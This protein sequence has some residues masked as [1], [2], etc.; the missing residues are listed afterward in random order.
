V[1]RLASVLPQDLS[2]QIIEAVI[3]LFNGSEFE[4]VAETDR[5]RISDPGGGSRGDARWH[6]VCLAL[7]ETARRGLI[8]EER[9]TE[10]LPWVIKVRSRDLRKYVL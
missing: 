8:D 3:D 7:A 5:G 6:G 1:A 2:T 9:L 10:M 4:P